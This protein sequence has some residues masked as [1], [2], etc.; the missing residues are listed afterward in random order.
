MHR[1]FGYELR[2][3]FW[4]CESESRALGATDHAS[5]PSAHE[6]VS[7]RR[8]GFAAGAGGGERGGTA[9]ARANRKAIRCCPPQRCQNA[10]RK[11]LGSQQASPPR[12]RT[13]LPNPPL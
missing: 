7:D 3:W 11:V 1:P 4:R 9:T 5:R 2:D 8:R 6:V 13:S 10:R 12:D